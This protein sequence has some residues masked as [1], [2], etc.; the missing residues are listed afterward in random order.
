MS[1]EEMESTWHDQPTPTSDVQTPASWI[2]RNQ[3]RYRGTALFIMGT[4]LLAS[5]N[6]GLKLLQIWQDPARTLANTSWELFIVGLTLLAALYGFRQ[7]AKGWRE[8]K[9][10]SHNTRA[11]LDTIIRETRR[12]IL[13]MRW[14]IP[15][16]YVGFIGLLVLAKFQ[17]IAAGHESSDN[18]WMGLVLAIVIFVLVSGFCFHRANAFLVPELKALRQTRQTLLEA[19]P[20]GSE[21]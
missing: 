4:T 13:A 7:F 6:F 15:A 18:A 3:R 17:S 19:G 16:A 10:L 9:T 11:C 8:F 5:V 2:D 1:I 21:A 12:E 14:G 20:P